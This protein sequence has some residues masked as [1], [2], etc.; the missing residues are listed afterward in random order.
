MRTS[1]LSRTP[2]SRYPGSGNR[3]ITAEPSSRA[4][5]TGPTSG[6]SITRTSCLVYAG[7]D[8]SVWTAPRRVTAGAGPGGRVYDYQADRLG[9][10]P[11]ALLGPR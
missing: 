4:L 3:N 7:D 6:T 10:F 11:G 2:A 1:W 5:A 9:H 8:N